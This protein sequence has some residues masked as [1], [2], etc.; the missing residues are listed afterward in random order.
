VSDNIVTLTVRGKLTQAD[1]AAAQKTAAE[2]IRKHGSIRVLVLAGQFSGW[3]QRGEW[4]DFAFQAEHDRSI[5]RMA[6]VGDEKWKELAL[7]FTAQGLREF[8]IEYFATEDLARAR[9]WLHAT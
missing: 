6:I 1:L 4:N 7:V 5:E 8:P 9:A 3:E 2:L